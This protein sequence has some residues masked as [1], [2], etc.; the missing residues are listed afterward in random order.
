MQ[1]Q[2]RGR[3]C[4][5]AVA[6]SQTLRRMS[7]DG[8]TLSRECMKYGSAWLVSWPIRVTRCRKRSGGSKLEWEIEGSGFWLQTGRAARVFGCGEA[9]K[10]AA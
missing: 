8:A 1:R 10:E 4:V 6:I 9:D 2:W 3:V 5:V 7:C